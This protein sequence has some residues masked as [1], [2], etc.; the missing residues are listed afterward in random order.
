ML[1][2]LSSLWARL[3][4]LGLS[5]FLA[6]LVFNMKRMG[7]FFQFFGHIASYLLYPL[8][9]DFYVA[10]PRLIADIETIILS[11]V[12]NGRA[13]V[14]SIA[15]WFK[16]WISTGS[17]EVMLVSRLD[18]SYD[19]KCP[20]I[21]LPIIIILQGM[22]S[23]TPQF[24]VVISFLIS[25]LSIFE[26]HMDDI[27][28][29]D[30]HT[31]TNQVRGTVVVTQIP[32]YAALLLKELGL[33]VKGLSQA[34]SDLGKANTLSLTSDEGIHGGP[35]K[36][37]ILD[38]QTIRHVPSLQLTWIG[39][40]SDTGQDALLQ[41]F[42]T[43]S[44]LPLIKGTELF[45]NLVPKFVSH[46]FFGIQGRL[47]T[48]IWLLSLF[49]PFNS[50]A[51]QLLLRL[52]ECYI[53][54]DSQIGYVDRAAIVS[55][56]SRGSV[57][58]YNVINNGGIHHTHLS[59]V[60][61]AYF[62]IDP[63]KW[64]PVLVSP[65]NKDT[66][67]QGRPI[68]VPDLNIMAKYSGQLRMLVLL[69]HATLLYGSCLELGLSPSSS[70]FITSQ[71]SVVVLN[72]SLAKHMSQLYV[73]MGI[74]ISS[75]SPST[76]KEGTTDVLV[77]CNG[78]IYFGGHLLSWLSP[79]VINLFLSNGAYGWLIQFL[80]QRSGTAVTSNQFWTMITPFLNKQDYKFMILL[81]TLPVAIT[82][83]TKPILP[84][85]L[86]VMG[87][88]AWYKE[89]SLEDLHI[90][91]LFTYLMVSELLISLD[92]SISRYLRLTEAMKT[93]AVDYGSDTLVNQSTGN[94][95]GIE[96]LNQSVADGVVHPL[97]PSLQSKISE[98]LSLC[99]SLVNGVELLTFIHV[100]NVFAVLELLNS[101]RHNEV[102][103]NWLNAYKIM[104]NK[105]IT[106]A[107][108]VTKSDHI[109]FLETTV[110]LHGFSHPF[111]VTWS[112]SKGVT[113]TT[114][115]SRNLL[116]MDESLNHGT[117]LSK[118]NYFDPYAKK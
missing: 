29:K 8:H 52:G 78:M 116:K 81:N 79:F 5:N 43:I 90:L 109:G 62:G 28:R 94:V 84:D 12:T 25:V 11:D 65:L 105:L 96:N 30:T 80:C 31:V 15:Q 83:F 55:G 98:I 100:L 38:A 18:W 48:N 34:V 51:K 10:I 42:E 35:A 49:A 64:L 61:K 85:K 57:V 24:S 9:K 17:N 114:L 63:S 72:E 13:R 102:Q 22:P 60:L 104:I 70:F 7:R 71:G 66:D 3:L 37:A 111:I 58:S 108:I 89:M 107:G 20:K 69:L 45:T 44:N 32:K 46:W 50:V 14:N 53:D 23:S 59:A 67:K 2:T 95:E 73:D 86:Q 33:D 19:H 74:N 56:N 92:A 76:P 16:V 117:T 27:L 6:I 82:G 93:I 41:Q 39:A 110:K 68:L 101:Q 118:I 113:L 88:G 99:Y 75:L 77:E 36:S 97:L 112:K 26:L 40:V 4:S 47:R 21:L 103:S 54:S 106:V 1:Q 91:S 115:Q 87:D